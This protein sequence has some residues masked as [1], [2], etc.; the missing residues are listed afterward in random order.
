M[1]AVTIVAT[2]VETVTTVVG[3]TL[4]MLGT[5]VAA[6]LTADTVE[7]MEV[8][9]PDPV[10]EAL[11]TGVYTVHT[12]YT[13]G[14]EAGPVVRTDDTGSEMVAVPAAEVITV[15]VSEVRTDRVGVAMLTMEVDGSTEIEELGKALPTAPDSEASKPSV[16]ALGAGAALVKTVPVGTVRRLVTTVPVGSVRTLV[17]TVP[18]GSVKTLVTTVPVGETGVVTTMPVDTPTDEMVV[19]PDV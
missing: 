9:T 11:H 15:G 17:T 5:M 7:A 12:V 14:S 1:L 6:E 13:D 18:V 3:S 16:V 19:A 8:T 4:T 10:A 2:D